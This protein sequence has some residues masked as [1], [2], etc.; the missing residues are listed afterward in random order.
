M[1]EKGINI[2]TLLK[3]L[4]NPEE[5]VKWD[6]DLRSAEVPRMENDNAMMIWHSQTKSTIKYILT[7]DYLEKKI[8][9]T[10]GNKKFVFF[11]A[12]PDEILAAGEGETRAYN[13]FGLHVFER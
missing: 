3:A 10:S 12:L 2:P 7:R 6:R 1:F 5:R 4:H 13:I 9:F 8:K 11:S